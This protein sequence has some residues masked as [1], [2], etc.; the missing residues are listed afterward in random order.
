[1]DEITMTINGMSCGHC[2]RAVTEALET[3]DGVEVE[4]VEVGAARV[5]YDPAVSSPAVIAQA[6]ED[7]G[8][9]TRPVTLGRGGGA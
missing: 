4:Q 6:V 5:A 1:M 7:A 2:V 8:Y 9:Q 3:L